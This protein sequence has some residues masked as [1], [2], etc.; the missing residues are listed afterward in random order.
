MYLLKKHSPKALRVL[1]SI[2]LTAI[3]GIAGLHPARALAQE[4]ADQEPADQTTGN[5]RGLGAVST[6]CNTM[7][8]YAGSNDGKRRHFVEAGL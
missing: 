3:L 7:N 6:R 5:L 8:G 1:L 4:A 2:M